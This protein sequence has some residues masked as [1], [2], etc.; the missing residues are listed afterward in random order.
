LLLLE[1]SGGKVL[2]SCLLRLGGGSVQKAGSNQELEVQDDTFLGKDQVT[3][4]KHSYCLAAT[5]L[6]KYGVPT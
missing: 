1:R 6:R 2:E 5:V 3:K 4:D